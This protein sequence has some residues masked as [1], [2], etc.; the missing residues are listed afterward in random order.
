MSISWTSKSCSPKIKLLVGYTASG[1]RKL[2][3]YSIRKIKPNTWDSS[4]KNNM[5][6]IL[7]EIA[8]SGIFDYSVYS[9]ECVNTYTGDF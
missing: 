5:N 9:L 7:E 6:N 1:G 2:T 8:E 3:T 4:L